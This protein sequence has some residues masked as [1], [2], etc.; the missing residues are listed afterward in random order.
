MYICKDI[1]WSELTESLHT[2]SAQAS[3]VPRHVTAP[4]FTRS[5]QKDRKMATSTAEARAAVRQ[6]RMV[7]CRLTTEYAQRAHSPKHDTREVVTA[8]FMSM[9]IILHCQAQGWS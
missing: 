3:C 5:D 1:Q 2:H 4:C 7:T 6:P 9:D 8:L